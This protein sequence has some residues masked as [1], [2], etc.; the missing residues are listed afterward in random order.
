MIF[1]SKVLQTRAP[2]TKYS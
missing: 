1:Q 2:S